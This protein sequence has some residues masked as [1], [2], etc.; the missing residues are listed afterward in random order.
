MELPEIETILIGSQCF[1]SKHKLVIWLYIKIL[2]NS[3][4]L[5]KIS[6]PDASGKVESKIMRINSP[7]FDL[8]LINAYI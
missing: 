8:N 3:L 4:I 2:S 6:F 5:I 7:S 1:P